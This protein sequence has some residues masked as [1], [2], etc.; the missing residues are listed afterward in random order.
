MSSVDQLKTSVMLKEKIASILCTTKM[1]KKAK[2]SM[3]TDLM[4]Y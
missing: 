4:F 3:F 1:Y 2:S